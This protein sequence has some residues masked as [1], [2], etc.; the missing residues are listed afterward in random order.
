MPKDNAKESWIRL[1]KKWEWPC[2]SSILSLAQQQ[3][4]GFRVVRSVRRFLKRKLGG[5]Q[6]SA[7][8]RSID[9]RSL[10]RKSCGEDGGESRRTGLLP[11]SQKSFGISACAMLEFCS[12]HKRGGQEK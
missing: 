3:S 8:F 11:R 9:Q 4:L 10:E 1:L 7:L 12:K 2:S 6:I 5:P